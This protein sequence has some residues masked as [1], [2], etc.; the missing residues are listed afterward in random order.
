MTEPVRRLSLERGDSV[1]AIVYNRTTQKFI[2][3]NQ[4][5]YPTFSKGP[6]WILETVAGMLGGSDSPES[7]IR[8]EILEE[9]GYQAD[10][11]QRIS[12]FYVSPGGS[13]ERV[14][15]YYAEVDDENRVGSGGGLAEETEDIQVLEFSLDELVAMLDS[16]EIRDAKTIIGVFWL[17]NRARVSK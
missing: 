12:V 8:R 13:S 7:A 14:F 10:T 11:L 9:T 2:L 16:A 6:G 3:V 4:F 15:L 5:K 17:I 1:S